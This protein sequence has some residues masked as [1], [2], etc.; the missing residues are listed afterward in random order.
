M[1]SRLGS[2]K[3][4]ITRGLIMQLGQGT[5]EKLLFLDSRT[6]HDQEFCY[7]KCHVFLHNGIKRN[8]YI[9]ALGAI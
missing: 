9:V 2:P 5:K 7:N 1:L 4:M 3:Y 6:C 8:Q